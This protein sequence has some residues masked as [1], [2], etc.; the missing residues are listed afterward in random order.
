MN[1]DAQSC[2]YSGRDDMGTRYVA[3]RLSQQEAEAFEA[4]WFACDACWRRVQRALELKAAFAGDAGAQAP[5]AEV[6]AA[7]SP[8]ARNWWPM[9]AS[10]AAAALLLGTWQMTSDNDVPNGVAMRGPG[11]SLQVSTRAE[12]GKLA[13]SWPPVPEADVYRVRVFS[14]NGTLLL[15]RE[16][17][18]NELE[19]RGA[20]LAKLDPG[21]A[22]YWSVD[23]L[24][25]LRRSV[26]RSELVE[27][28]PATSP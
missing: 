4:H 21:Q 16:T 3:G 8:D 13:A 9:A 20:S 2:E 1:S 10:V 22:V 28:I 24:D 17:R 6:A 23:A 7:R 27:A 11:D 19:I 25:E 5:S 15:E 12:S 18:G 26:A 14:G